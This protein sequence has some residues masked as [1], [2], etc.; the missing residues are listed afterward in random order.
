MPN[1]VSLHVVLVAESNITKVAFVRFVFE[2]DC[3]DVN[4]TVSYSATSFKFF[5]AHRAYV[6]LI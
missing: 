1:E 3:V 5:L 6:Q 2:V 4:F